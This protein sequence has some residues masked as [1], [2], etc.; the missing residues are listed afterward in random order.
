M[1]TTFTMR[2]IAVIAVVLGHS[3]GWIYLGQSWVLA[4]MPANTA[5]FASQ[6]GTPVY[7]LLQSI[8]QLTLCDV[9]IFIFAS[10]F[11]LSYVIQNEEALKGGMV[12]RWIVKVAWPFLIWVM[13]Q[14][15]ADWLPLALFSK[16]GHP[17]L[18]LSMSEAVKFSYFVVLIIQF[19]L[20]APVIARLAKSHWKLLVGLSLAI[21]LATSAVW[22]LAMTGV[23]N[24]PI[25]NLFLNTSFYGFWSW[26]VY[27]VLGVT[28]G[29][30]LGKVRQ[31][32]KPY[33][34]YLAW[35]CLVF[36][37]ASI[38]ETRLLFRNTAEFI[39][40][41]WS[42]TSLLYFLAVILTLMMVSDRI[43]WL[44]KDMIELG[45]K[46]L[47]IYLSQYIFL[48]TIT[49]SVYHIYPQLL[50]SPILFLLLLS[51]VTL[52]LV[53][54]VSNAVRRFAPRSVY[55]FLYG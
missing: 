11:M 50:F 19:Y 14:I 10:G 16:K 38:A 46:S 26:T 54:V 25:A 27:Y 45:A 49:R 41:N 15:L 55:N 8:L 32:L 37:L 42:I 2:G 33:V 17:S 7:Y 23:L 44:K 9:P 6:I 40:I 51:G 28:F 53:I 43:K 31:H 34:P 47:G 18:L 22:Y 5:L 3:I 21:Q 39:P 29:V 35:S 4:S 52:G 36:G 12:F 20:L 30:N 13:L 24:H 1:K 48:D